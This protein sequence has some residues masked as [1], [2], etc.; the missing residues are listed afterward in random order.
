VYIVVFDQYKYL[1]ILSL[2]TNVSLP[3]GRI[4]VYAQ[5]SV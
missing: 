4:M 3:H 2:T 5:S 1:A